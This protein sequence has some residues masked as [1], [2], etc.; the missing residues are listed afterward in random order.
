[1]TPVGERGQFREAGYAMSGKKKLD[2]IDV[3]FG[4]SKIRTGVMPAKKD[5]GE[6]APSEH[7]KQKKT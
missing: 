3:W 5:K 1:M 2:V 6:G 4:V 7:R